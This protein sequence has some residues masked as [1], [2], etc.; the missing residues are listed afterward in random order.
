M[1][2]TRAQINKG[3]LWV[4]GSIGYNEQKGEPYGT[5][6]SPY[7]SNAFTINP[8][9]GTVVKDN[10]VVGINL[11]YNQVKTDNDG[12][13]IKSKTNAY[14]GGVFVRKY[15]P[16]ISRLYI[17]GDAGVGFTS[18]KTDKTLPNYYNGVPIKTT[19]K[20]WSGAVG[21]TPG[22]AFA[23]S[24]KFQLETSLNNLFSVAYNSNKTTGPTDYYKGKS[25][26][27]SAGLYADGQA[28]FNIGFRFLFNNKG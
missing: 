13:S 14:G 25:H 16:V 6:A 9:I 24:K 21:I 3:A 2:T 22:I 11:L 23:V 19:S 8:S 12:N 28:Q 10:L 1:V 15:F 20:G 5:A 4:G 18:T 27:L 26:Q 7:K 17:F